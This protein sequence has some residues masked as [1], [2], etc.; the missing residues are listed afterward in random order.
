MKWLT[1]V[2]VLDSNLSLAKKQPQ[3]DFNLS[4]EINVRKLVRTPQLSNKKKFC[5]QVKEP[6]TTQEKKKLLP[7]SEGSHFLPFGKSSIKLN[8]TIS[9]T[10]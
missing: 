6:Y 9:N 8:S 10:T 5:P 2:E 7:T 4:R 1:T 3:G